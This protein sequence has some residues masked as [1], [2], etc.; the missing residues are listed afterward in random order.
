MHA[1]FPSLSHETFRTLN[2]ERLIRIN[3]FPAADGWAPVSPGDVISI[4]SK[5]G[6]LIAT[7]RVKGDLHAPDATPEKSAC[8]PDAVRQAI[9]RFADGI[10]HPPR[11]VNE[12]RMV[13]L[14]DA[15]EHTRR[16]KEDDDCRQ[17]CWRYR[18]WRDFVAHV[19]VAGWPR[20]YRE[21]AR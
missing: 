6:A 19:L 8:Q 5:D 15:V 14:A 20:L 2:G 12:T 17:V 3:G 21:D 18:R 9:R 11:M 4:L 16:D 7:F 10:W 13:G 1:H